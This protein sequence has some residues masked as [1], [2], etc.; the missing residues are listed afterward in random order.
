M[1]F[2][3]KDFDELFHSRCEELAKVRNS[4][5]HYSATIRKIDIYFHFV[6][7]YEPL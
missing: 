5:T 6:F 1:C 7:Y 3:L 2:K 4:L